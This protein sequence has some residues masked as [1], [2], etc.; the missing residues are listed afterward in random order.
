MED[1][2]GRRKGSMCRGIWM[3]NGELEGVL[4]KVTRSPVAL[5]IEKFLQK[6]H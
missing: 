3:D 6:G 1:F 2:Y 4:K 5:F